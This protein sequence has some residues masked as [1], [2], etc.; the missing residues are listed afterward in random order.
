MRIA[1]GFGSRW[2]GKDAGGA[3]HGR[4]VMDS[5]GASF[6]QVLEGARERV[7]F[8]QH[9]EERLQRRGVMLTNT[10]L[11]KLGSTIDRMRGE[12]RKGSPDLY[13][14]QYG[15]GRLCDEPHRDHGAR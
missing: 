9:A 6:A 4:K 15:D 2:S 8:S 10:E 12:G 5:S 7:R 14:G 13:E 1:D 3:D 11:E